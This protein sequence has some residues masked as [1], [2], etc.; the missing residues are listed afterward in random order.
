MA[1]CGTGMGALAGMLA[2][3]GYRVSGSDDQI[4]PPMSTQLQSL[5][6]ELKLGYR[7]ENLEPCPDLVIVGNAISRSH[8][9]AQAM[10]AQ[11]LPHLS[12][13][14]A[15]YQF[16]L[17]DRHPIVITGTHGKTTTSALTAWLL[18]AG[19]KDPGFMVGGI[20]VNYGHNY[21][22]G[23]GPTF[24]VEGDEYDS[25]FFDKGP[26]FLHYAPQTAILTSVEYDHADIYPSLEAVVEAFR[27]FVALLPEAGLLLACGDD[28]IVRQLTREARCRV[29]TYGLDPS[30]FWSAREIRFDEMGTHFLLCREGEAVGWLHSPLWGAHNL[31]N[32]L[33]AIGTV[34]SQQ[35]DLKAVC[36]GL[37]RFRGVRK[38][39][40]IKGE[41]GSILVLDDFAHHPTAVRET[42]RA[43][44]GRF[45]GRRLWAAFEPRTNT[46]RRK[47]FQEAYAQ[48]FDT[49]D[50][51]VVA[52]VNNPQKVPPEERFSPEQ[53]AEDLRGRGKE[54]H[55]FPEIQAMIDYLSQELCSGDV[56]LAMSNGDFEGFHGR[57]LAR[58]R[59]IHRP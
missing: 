3:S 47:V 39:Q 44:R 20:L 36:G 2:S 51:V 43:A 45:P 59:E 35:V 27:Q 40:E 32:T 26:K 8:P 14:Q 16:Y 11:G 29:Q 12:F 9:E 50:R 34:L 57:L 31:R 10:L 46:S 54:A 30:H 19:E 18:E 17:V 4:Y 52:P 23:S 13:P 55:Y 58:L 33:A 48:A 25:A 5:G 56:V 38:R 1:I 24:V 15:L 42:L 22:V 28:P 7:P 21:K 53:L 41:V 37:E 49:A 6:I